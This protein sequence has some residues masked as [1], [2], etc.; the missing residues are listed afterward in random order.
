M[1]NKHQIF[2][3]SF[4]GPNFGGGGGG[5]LVGPNSQICPKIRFE[6][7]PYEFDTKTD[8]KKLRKVKVK[9]NETLKFNNQ[10]LPILAF[11]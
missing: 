7:F 6:G 1:Q 8:K 3:F 5:N 2:F 9:K 10:T 4:G 11:C